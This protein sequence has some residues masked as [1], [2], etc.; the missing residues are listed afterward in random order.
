[1]K[2]A[3]TPKKEQGMIIIEGIMAILIFSLGVLAIV[4]MQAVSIKNS[5]DS[6]YRSD[7]SF[8]ANQI[9]GQMWVDQPNLAQYAHHATAGASP[10]TPGGAPSGNANVTAWLATLSSAL[11]GADESKQQIAIGANNVVTVT[12]CWR[13]PQETQDHNFVATAQII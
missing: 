11:P 6:K 12:V 7:A 10:C 9:I 13:G 3:N 5:A 1:M 2:R 4:G 8:L